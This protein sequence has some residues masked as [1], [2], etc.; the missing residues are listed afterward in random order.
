M[1]FVKI[2]KAKQ[3]RE[4]KRTGAGYKKTEKEEV[5]YQTMQGV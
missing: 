5:A 1:I 4:F 2:L 3:R